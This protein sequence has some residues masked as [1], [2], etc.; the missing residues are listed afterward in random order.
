MFKY[1]DMSTALCF[2]YTVNYSLK[3]IF[4]LFRYVSTVIG[5]H[6]SHFN[7]GSD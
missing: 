6:I 3:N 4:N 5:M 2:S 1:S 7:N